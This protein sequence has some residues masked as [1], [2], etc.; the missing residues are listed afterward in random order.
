MGPKAEIFAGCTAISLACV[1]DVM[2]DIYLVASFIAVLSGAILGVH[3]L[4]QLVRSKRN[5]NKDNVT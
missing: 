1:G 5:K 4:Y 3:G 2:H